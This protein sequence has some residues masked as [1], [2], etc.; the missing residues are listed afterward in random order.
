[1]ATDRSPRTTG[2]GLP[3]GDA[4]PS[5]EEIQ[6][7]INALY[8]RAE[9][10]TGNFNATRVMATASSVIA[11]AGPSARDNVAR[12]WFDVARSKLGPTVAA[13]LPPDRMP[14]PTDSRPAKA[15]ERATDAPQARELAAAPERRTPE[16]TSRSA[17]AA[18]P[19]APETRQATPALPAPAATAQESSPRTAKERNR[20]KLTTARDLLSRHVA[21]RATPVAAL[22]A[23]PA[24]QSWDTGGLPAVAAEPRP[25]AQ[26]W[27]TG[28]L[29]VTA[30][31]AQPAA[32][33]WDTGSLPAVPPQA[34][35]AAQTWN[36]GGLPAVPPQAQPAAQTWDTGSLPTV[37][38]PAPQAW[39]TGSLPVTTPAAAPIPQPWDT[40]SV[41]VAQPAAAPWPTQQPT[42]A[43][44]PFASVPTAPPVA[45]VVSAPPVASVVSAP[46]V[47]SVAS[48][49]LVA[50]VP[51]VA[52]AVESVYQGKAARALD[53]TRAQ[54]GKPC[55]WGAN[56]P[57]SYDCSS[58]T[59]AAWRAAGVALPR[60]AQEQALTGT[61]IPLTDLQVGDLVFFHG[62][63][64]V[65]LYAGNGMM[66]HAPSPGAYIREESVL[67]AGESAVLGAVRP[68]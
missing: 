31:E 61:A 53:F 45:S 35:P 9:S 23:A 12:Q 65:G 14:R 54:I 6:Q 25:A 51:S 50:S 59:Q 46:P 16:L 18:L 7:R 20:R 30:P 68:A 10:D 37:P 41:P 26:T 1:M 19:A 13:V 52:G 60:S 33:T 47:A 15:P 55:V 62:A 40:G 29:P 28:S 42:S 32:Q 11:P 8:N 3:E 34:Q 27:D 58:L 39:D 57:T 49:P 66:I 63:S 36:T 67:Y 43:G 5:R 64:H 2:I 17:V 4:E 22:E 24:P 44:Q 21:Q 38:P 56:G 48:A